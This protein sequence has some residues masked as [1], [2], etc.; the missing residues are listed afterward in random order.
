MAK[1]DRTRPDPS[2]YIIPMNLNGLNG[3]MLKMPA[4]KGKEREI[5]IVYGMHASIERMF[6]LA[7][8]LNKYGSITIA[9]LP[10]FGGMDSFYKIGEVPTLD[11]M[12]DY[13]ATLVKMRYRR[14]K[15]T[16]IGMSY[17]FVVAT[18][19]LQ[20]FPE[21]RSKVN[22][23]VSLVGFAHHEDFRMSNKDMTLLKTVSWIGSHKIP[24]DFIKTFVFRGPLIRAT[25]KTVAKR[26][27]KMYDADETEL[28]NRINYEIKLWKMNDPRTR[29]RISYDIFNVNLCDK[30]VDM[31]M[32][33]VAIADDHF[34]NNTVV[35]QH[36]GVIYNKVTVIYAEMEGHAPTVIAD[37]EAAAPFI[38]K[39]LR[40]LLS[41]KPK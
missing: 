17:G 12:A 1:N 4:P 28:N 19:M 34:F 2:D 41:K 21:L 11:N 24:S 40:Q 14:K 32:Y 26:H 13:L 23:L 38:P 29:G 18:R 5:L 27:R 39:K 10:G 3:R 33:H 8:D 7:E 30:Q 15:L 25:Y 36:L 16:L 20:K 31:P 6:G 35:E 22:L 9:D 37:A